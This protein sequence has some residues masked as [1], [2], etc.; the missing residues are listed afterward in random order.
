MTLHTVTSMDS[1]SG[2]SWYLAQHATTGRNALFDWLCDREVTPWTPLHIHM[3]K[4]T[5]R[6]GGVRRTIRPV[7]PGYFFL[8][9]DFARHPIAEIKSHSAF[10]SFVQFGA[11]VS[12]VSERLVTGLQ[13]FYPDPLSDSAAIREAHATPDCWLT[14]Q[15]YQHLVHLEENARPV[16]RIKMLM[17]MIQAA[18]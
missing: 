13:R 4:R 3:A 17:D 10:I 7:F 11:G 5:D 15:Q 16:S 14:R 1:T 12:P 9:A 2:P 18:A 8:N 6:V